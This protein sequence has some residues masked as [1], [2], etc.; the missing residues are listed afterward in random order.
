MNPV[1]LRAYLTRSTSPVTYAQVRRDLAAP[2]INAVTQA[3]ELM[4][5]EDAKAGRPFLA[6]LVVSR[7]HPLPARGF[8]DHARSLGRQIDD[9]AAFHRAELAALGKPAPL[10]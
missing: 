4:M 10:P 5:N 3:L 2:S 1:V 7:S 6:A 9:D 8:F